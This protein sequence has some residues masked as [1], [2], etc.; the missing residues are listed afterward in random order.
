MAT[1]ASTTRATAQ[2]TA[3]SP[4]IQMTA[5]P[6]FYSRV[7]ISQMESTQNPA[8]TT[9][10]NTLAEN[11]Q[12]RDVVQSTVARTHSAAAQ[13][14]VQPNNTEEADSNNTEEGDPS[15]Q[16]S[17]IS[18]AVSESLLNE[19]N[20]HLETLYHLLECPVCYDKFRPGTKN[21]GMCFNGHLL[22]EKCMKYL[23]HA[24]S[25]CPTCRDP[26]LILYRDNHFI[27][28]V[29]KFITFDQEFVCD[30]HPCKVLC[31]GGDLELHESVCKKM[32]V[33]CPAEA[34]KYYGPFR[35]FANGLHDCV[36]P[37]HAIEL[38]NTLYPQEPGS[39]PKLDQWT[40]HIPLKDLFSVDRNSV[41]LHPKMKV[42]LLKNKTA[43]FRLFFYPHQRYD[44]VVF[45]IMWMAK[46]EHAVKYAHS[47]MYRMWVNISVRGGHTGLSTHDSVHC[48]DDETIFTSSKVI[49]ITANMFR[50]WISVSDS[51][52]LG[53]KMNDATSGVANCNICKVSSQISGPHLHFY[54]VVNKPQ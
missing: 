1:I 43:D 25:V 14:M 23:N 39:S 37:M 42:L 11:L 46:R 28:T 2:D 45:P 47:M 33:Y 38:N 9:Q 34:C 17:N 32:S 35:F 49:Q 26:S 16:D 54:V 5:T 20:P 4:R 22:C 6:A 36:Q 52:N 40:F 51:N 29:I 12:N 48:L 21:V 31:S 15:E 19:Y 8:P 13:L 27:N 18:S 7:T 24:N 44:K 53:G 30:L 3:D 41:S 50:H 10:T